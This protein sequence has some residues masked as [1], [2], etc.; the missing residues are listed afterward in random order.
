MYAHKRCMK[1][2]NGDTY[3]AFMKFS[4]EFYLMFTE[5]RYRFLKIRHGSHD[6]P[7]HDEAMR[8]GVIAD[9][10]TAYYSVRHM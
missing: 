10:H 2:V 1:I 9:V 5:R 7:Q 3:Q 4:C 6:A 8:T